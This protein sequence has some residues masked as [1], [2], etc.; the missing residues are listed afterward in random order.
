M[1]AAFFSC[2]NLLYSFVLFLYFGRCANDTLGSEILHLDF[3]RDFDFSLLWFT[4]KTRLLP[5][6]V[7]IA[8]FI[9]IYLFFSLGLIMMS[10]YYKF[11]HP[12]F[13]EARF[14]LSAPSKSELADRD[15]KEGTHETQ[16]QIFELWI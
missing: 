7:E 4:N 3:H 10:V 13:K 8:G 5:L 2:A 11:L 15:P 16:V 9:V 14:S 12:R 1:E 6:R